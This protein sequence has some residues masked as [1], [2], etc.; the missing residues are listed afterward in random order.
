MHESKI[1][2]LT[3]RESLNRG[4]KDIKEHT[5]SI[6]LWYPKGNYQVHKPQWFGEMPSLQKMKAIKHC[7]V[8]ILLAKEEKLFVV[9]NYPR[10]V[11]CVWFHVAERILRLKHELGVCMGIQSYG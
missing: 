7:F 3:Q 8:V 6:G 10:S 1:S 2:S 11:E 4:E 9:A 5:P